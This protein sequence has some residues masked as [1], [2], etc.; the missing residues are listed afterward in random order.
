MATDSNNLLLQTNAFSKCAPN[1]STNIK[2]CGTV[3]LCNAKSMLSTE[4]A[5]SYTRSG[6]YLVMEALLQTDFEIKMCDTVQNT[7]YDFLMA[8][9]VSISAKW[10]GGAQRVNSGLINI[11]PFVLARQ[12]SAINNAYWAVSGG[13]S[14]GENWQVDVAST[15]NIPPDVRSFAVDERV[16]ITGETGGGTKTMTSW[17]VVSATLINNAVR[18]VLS[19]QNSGS[20]LASSRLASPV[21]GI[22]TRGTANKNDYEKYCA[23]PPAYLNWKN[24]P[25]WVE[26]QRTSM[27]KSSLYDKFRK[28]LMEGNP[29]YRE[30]GDLD[31][32]ERNRQL[33]ADWQRRMVETMFWG[34]PISANQTLT[35]Y[36]SLEDIETF[37]GGSL[38]VDGAKCVGKRANMVGI[39]EQLAQCGRVMDLQGAQLNLISL[40]NEL[41]NIARTRQGAGKQQSTVIDIFTDNITAEAINQAM[42]SYYLAKSQ[43]TLRVTVPAGGN[44]GVNFNRDQDLQKAEFGFNY[45]SYNLFYP[46]NVR[47]NII[48]HY[49]FDDYLTANS[50]VSGQSNAGRLLLVLDFSGIYPGIASSNRVVQKTGDLKTLASISPDFGCVL[51]V[52][53]QEQTLTSVT[54]TM[55]VECPAGNL[56]LE[57][58]SSAVPAVTSGGPVYPPTTTTTTTTST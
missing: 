47:I 36:S 43:N 41:Y 14:S 28:L 55:I 34:K 10:K 33:G 15:T 51:Q 27:C 37:D 20:Y 52:P 1:I 29:L 21:T 54:G 22:L 13:T 49:F 32:I 5:S 38:G 16:Y 39:Y 4:L 40:F 3:T 6:E 17:K 45:R 50:S 11:A 26:T 48:S 8:N 19:P 58:F 2:Q 35:L 57:N 46:A 23:E 12:Y 30:Y 56:W 42:I 44:P 24:V 31:E 9:K 7:L 53:T 18:L 25:F